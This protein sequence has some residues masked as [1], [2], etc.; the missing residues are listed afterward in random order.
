MADENKN[1]AIYVI[2]AHTQPITEHNRRVGIWIWIWIYNINWLNAESTFSSPNLYTFMLY[3]RL[4]LAKYSYCTADD[5]AQYWN[6]VVFHL[7]L[8]MCENQS[9]LC[10]LT[11]NPGTMRRR[12]WHKC[13]NINSNVITIG[14]IMYAVC[15][16]RAKKKLVDRECRQ[17]EHTDKLQTFPTWWA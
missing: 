15:A 12:N 14:S 6:W 1:K 8:Y 5:I 2:R 11:W 10:A 13:M 7:Y 16:A 17:F 3:S 9:N 4:I